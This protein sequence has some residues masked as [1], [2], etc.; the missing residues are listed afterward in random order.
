MPDFRSG[1]AALSG[2]SLRDFSTGA[3]TLRLLPQ[4]LSENDSIFE[5]RPRPYLVTRRW[6]YEKFWEW[7][8]D[9]PLWQSR[10]LGC[11]PEQAQ[12]ALISLKWLEAARGPKVLPNDEVRLYAGIDSADR[13]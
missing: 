3:L 6:V 2:R 10:V 9:S 11:F 4:G 1:S 12:D 5:Y 8:E 7:G 13:R